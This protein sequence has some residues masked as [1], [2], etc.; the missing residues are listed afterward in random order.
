MH[1]FSLHHV[2]NLKELY[3]KYPEKELTFSFASGL[4]QTHWLAQTEYQ[5]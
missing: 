4:W 2:K 3:L 5:Y 1:K